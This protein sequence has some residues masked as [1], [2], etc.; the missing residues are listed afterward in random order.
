MFDNDP[1]LLYFYMFDFFFLYS[2]TVT[3]NVLLN[4]F[5]QSSRSFLIFKFLHIFIS[6]LF[7][8]PHRKSTRREPGLRPPPALFTAGIFPTTGDISCSA[9]SS[10]LLLLIENTFFFLLSFP[11]L[12]ETTCLLSREGGVSRRLADIFVFFTN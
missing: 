2:C 4:G 5:I 11:P 9:C 8:P 6:T 10:A 7:S 1:Y 12:S 3:E